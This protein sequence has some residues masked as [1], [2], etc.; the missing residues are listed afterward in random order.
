[1]EKK[2][3][4]F[5]ATLAM[6]AVSCQ[7]SVNEYPVEAEVDFKATVEKFDYQT[8]TSLNADRQ[9]VWSSGDRIAIFQGSTLAD[10]YQLKNAYAGLS[11]GSYYLVTDNSDVNGD[12]SA[13]NELPCN[14]AFYPYSD[15]LSLSGKMVEDVGSAYSIENFI[16]P[17]VQIYCENSFGNGAFPM[18]A[19]TENM[20]DHKLQFKKITLF[21]KVF[22]LWVRVVFI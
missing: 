3:I 9:V 20:A 15:D 7:K 22:Y 14:V 1:M 18:V 4:A 6:I 5:V 21:L 8:K 12:F 17:E 11:N 19:V 10:E 13:G 2:I 16:L